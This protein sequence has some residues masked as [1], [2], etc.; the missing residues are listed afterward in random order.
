MQLFIVICTHRALVPEHCLVGNIHF[1]VDTSVKYASSSAT[2]DEKLYI[3][4]C[5]INSIQPIRHPLN[6]DA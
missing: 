2:G 6:F 5:Y 3:V 1:D 4:F